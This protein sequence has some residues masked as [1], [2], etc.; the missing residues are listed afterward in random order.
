MASERADPYRA[1]DGFVLRTPLLPFEA[2]EAWSAGLDFAEAFT[3]EV[4]ELRARLRAIVT[5]PELADALFVASPSL[6]DGLKEW[7]RDPTC[8]RGQKVEPALIR[9]FMRMASRPT[10]FGLF[11]GCSVGTLGE[12][13]HLELPPR[14]EYRRH[15][16]LDMDYL[17]SLSAALDADPELR[18][19]VRYRPNSSLYRA[20]DQI[21][22]FEPRLDGKV[23]SYHLVSV[24]RSPHLDA[25]LARA[26]EGATR[27]ALAELAAQLVEEVAIEEAREFIDGLI[28]S[29]ILVSPLVPAVTGQEPIHELIDQLRTLPK[30][31]ESTAR[32]LAVVRD[33]LDRID[34]RGLGVAAESYRAIAED[35]ARLPASVELGRLFQV[36]VIKPATKMTLSREVAREILATTRWLARFRPPA[37]DGDPRLSRFVAAFEAR[38]GEEEVALSEALDEEL[39]VGFDAEERYAEHAPLLD[40]IELAGQGDHLPTWTASDALLLR[41][42]SEA[43]SSGVQEISLDEGDL[44]ST[45][46]ATKI[47]EAF[48]AIVV[49]GA[50]L[51]FKSAF[52]PSGARI[53]GRFCHTDPAIE[54]LVRHH[55]D[56]EERLHPETIFAEVAH[57]PEG[58]IGNVIC[59]PVLRGYEIPFVG[60]SGASEDRQLPV[61]D[62]W[63]SVRG[64]RIFLRSKRLGRLVAPRITNAHNLSLP[65]SLGM[66]RFLGAL[67]N[68]RSQEGIFFSWG[69]LGSAPFLPRVRVGRVV[70]SRAQWSITKE[71]LS[72]LIESSGADRFRAAQSLRDRRKLSRFV[73]LADGD[74]ELLVDFDNPLCLDA[75]L[76]LI[77]RRTAVTLVELYPFADPRIC[78]GPEGKFAH[79]VVVSFVS[80]ERGNTELAPAEHTPVIA[81]RLKPPGSGCLY[82]KLYGGASSLERLLVAHLAP[83]F[84]DAR[85]AG[86]IERWFFVRYADPQTHLRLRFFGDPERLHAKLLPILQQRASELAGTGV[87]WKVQLDTY[88]QELARYGG[89]HGL[90]LAEQLFHADSEA[91]LAVLALLEGDDGELARWQLALLGIDLL[92]D[93]M[94][95]DFAAKQTIAGNLRRGYRAEF[96]AGEGPLKHALGAHFRRH[97]AAID[98]LFDPSSGAARELAPAIELFHRRSTRLAPIAAELRANIDAKKISAS[99]DQLLPSYVHMFCN[100]ILRSSLRRQELVLYEFLARAYESRSAREGAR[101]R[102]QKTDDR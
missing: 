49:L 74:H 85:D 60:R 39:G 55:L 94:G 100:R 46:A 75:F 9:Y 57:L 54:E 62:L 33:R 37:G 23:R 95:L 93:G 12:S 53:L 45:K 34:E 64:G 101:R 42:L 6:A 43:L 51:V 47:P 71:E 19:L 77:G 10:P 66:Y 5:Q 1:D 24:E 15:T 13:T 102:G 18:G 78:R 41:K 58:R 56:A 72:P 84:H 68:E 7:L 89:V 29:H 11:S 82:F 36:D 31:G 98:A 40:G 81:P 44:P 83:L 48:A 69:P 27:D 92:L 17:F 88:E 97:R 35:L 14:H 50:E 28:D 25:V 63:V 80:N 59:R 8:P 16:R 65:G 87:L 20:G 70:V 91:V 76:E 73:L 99:I 32:A 96:R 52:G 3:R 30:T 22:Y 4:A 21:R 61:A 38:Y 26:Q 90:Q 86:V 2:V 79:E 67:Q